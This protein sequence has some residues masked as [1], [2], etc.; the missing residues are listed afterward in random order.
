V[1][2]K[3]GGRFRWVADFGEASEIKSIVDRWPGQ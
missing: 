1:W 3:D 2:V